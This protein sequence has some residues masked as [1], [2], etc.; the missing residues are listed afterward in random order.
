MDAAGT[1]DH[2]QP[3]VSAVEDLGYLRAPA[4]HDLRWLANQRQ[5]IDDELR[6]RERDY[7]LDPPVAD[8]I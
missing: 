6:G 5:L 3:I 7:L 8:V 2:E 4:E 1:N